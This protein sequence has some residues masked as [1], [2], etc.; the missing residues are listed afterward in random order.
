MEAGPGCGQVGWLWT[1][2]PCSAL[3]FDCL[4]YTRARIDS[5]R[6]TLERINEI[7]NGSTR[8][9]PHL[10]I[11][12]LGLPWHTFEC[13]ASPLGDVT[14]SAEYPPRSPSAEKLLSHNKTSR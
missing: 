5:K 14:N 13:R 9:G 12:D 2:T 3:A 7:G 11:M 10:S 8:T 1:S 6:P 4:W